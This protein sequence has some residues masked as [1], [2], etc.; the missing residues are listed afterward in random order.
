MID[1]MD[2]R[3]Q[4]LRHRITIM[5]SDTV[6]QQCYRSQGFEANISSELTITYLPD[7]KMRAEAKFL[8]TPGKSFTLTVTARKEA[9]LC[10]RLNELLDKEEQQND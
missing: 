9:T 3:W 1:N 8:F 7:Q 4:R 6:G 10:K 2:D 5:A